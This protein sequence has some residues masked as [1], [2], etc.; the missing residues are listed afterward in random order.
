MSNH[1][2]SFMDPL[3][4]ADS[5]NPIVFF[6][7]RSDV[8]VPWLKPVLWGARMLPI[9]R[10]Q[11]GEDTKKKNHEVFKQCSKILQGGENLIVFSEGF[12]DDTFVRRLKPIKKGAVRIGFTALEECNWKKKIFI[13]AVGINYSDPNYVGGDCV[14]SNGEPVCLNNYKHQYE[15]DPNK[16]IYELT[17]QMELSMRAQITDVRDI[18]LT[19]FHES[20]MRITR[21]GMNAI[22]T[23]KSIPLLDRWNYSKNLAHWIN[24]ENITANDEVMQLKDK[25]ET[26]FSLL[27]QKRIEETPLYNVISNQR[28]KLRERAY[29]FFLFPIML[30]GVL[31]NY[32]P[33]M[34]TKNMVEGAMK[35]RVF[36]GS[37]KMNVGL[38]FTGIYN[39]LLFL[40]VSFV[41]PLPFWGLFCVG[42]FVI[43]ITGLI[44][45]QWRRRLKEY[46][47]MNKIERSDISEIATERTHI[48]KEIKRL[49][50]VA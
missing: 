5:Q 32:I 31:F 19:T 22:D 4:I 17:Q 2:A 49:I 13:Q 30:I 12:T 21:K 9:Y 27:K 26:Y 39:I 33:Y 40:L 43:P 37:V 42:L 44:A 25:M 7:T 36:W 34:I 23:D 11:D 41:T 3:I 38:V 35:R 10:E 28:E 8:F 15:S 6:M 20:I 14:V 50:P 48:L 47:K 45:Y 1:A 16:I 24:T 29:L 18:H 46:V